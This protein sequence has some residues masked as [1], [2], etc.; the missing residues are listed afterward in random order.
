MQLREDEIHNERRRIN[1]LLDQ[2]ENQQRELERQRESSRYQQSQ[3]IDSRRRGDSRTRGAPH[4][5]KRRPVGVQPRRTRMSRR[6]ARTRGDQPSDDDDDQDDDI[7]DTPGS[8]GFDDAT[9]REMLGPTDPRIRRR[10]GQPQGGQPQGGQRQA[11]QQGNQQQQQQNNQQQRQQ[12]QQPQQQREGRQGTGEGDNDNDN[13]DND[14]GDQGNGGGDRRAPPGDGNRRRGR[15]RR[16]AQRD[17]TLDDQRYA[18]AMTSIQQLTGAVQTFV[19]NQN[20]NQG[21]TGENEM[22][23]Q[24]AREQFKLNIRVN[25][26]KFR[27]EG[28]DIEKR[29]L[30][31]INESMQYILNSGLLDTDPP[32]EDVAVKNLSTYGLGGEARKQ[33]NN[34]IASAGDFVSCDDYFAWLLRLYPLRTILKECHDKLFSIKVSKGTR[35]ELLLQPYHNAKK[36]YELAIENIEEERIKGYEVDDEKHARLAENTLPESILK[37]YDNWVIIK[38]YEV[39][40]LVDVQKTL[41]EL[42]DYEEQ[43]KIARTNPY[44]RRNIKDKFGNHVNAMQQDRSKKNKPKGGKRFR[45]GDYNKSYNSRRSGSNFYYRS[46][47]KKNVYRDNRRNNYNNNRRGYNQ[48]RRGYN[49]SSRGR[50]R[51]SYRGSNRGRSTYRGSYR[52][53]YRGRGSGQ[54]YRG[55]YRG[56]GRGSYRGNSS[57][58]GRGR[59]YG[60]RGSYNRGNQRSYSRQYDDRSYSQRP[61]GSNRSSYPTRPKDGTIELTEDSLQTILKQYYFNGKCNYCKMHGHKQ[62]DCRTLNQY[63]QNV[64]GLLANKDGDTYNGTVSFITGR[65]GNDHGRS[66]NNNNNNNDNNNNNNNNSNDNNDDNRSSRDTN[67]GTVGTIQSTQSTP[68]RRANNRTFLLNRLLQNSGNGNTNRS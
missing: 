49:G 16:P 29:L 6:R 65:V 35:W 12:Q 10:G 13:N 25:V 2:Q 58:R 44:E 67:M 64:K 15:D 54:G 38:N 37:K 63:S 47:K 53:S 14:G 39:L 45:K 7:D 28:T 1:Q 19:Q 61:R 46:Q 24:I 20:Q 40:N 32:H 5:E 27:G 51:G 21:Q 26:T 66:N 23:K 3:Q 59:S 42:R 17:T 56:S 11:G 60:G 33:Y 68:A 52:G 31:Y 18:Q 62:R 8:F 22:Q 36:M 30:T 50:G 57:S 48:S 43:K 55:S 9:M 4:I 41:D 34:H